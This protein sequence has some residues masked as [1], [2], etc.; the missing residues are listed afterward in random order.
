MKIRR[1]KSKKARAADLAAQ[2]LKFKAVTKAVKAAPKAAWVALAGG[3]AGAAAMK[4]RRRRTG[5]SATA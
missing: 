3:A 5:T 1:Q 2:Y 4:A